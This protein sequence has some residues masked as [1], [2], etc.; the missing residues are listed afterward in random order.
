MQWK[1]FATLAETVGT[2]AVETTLDADDPTLRDALCDLLGS[3]PELEAELLDDEDSFHAHVRLL[4]DGW[5]PF[6]EGEG[7]Q[8]S[9]SDVEEVAIFPPVA[10]G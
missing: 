9:V 6:Q 5:D 3:Y 4:C 10:G 7:W 2:T 1:L 8:E